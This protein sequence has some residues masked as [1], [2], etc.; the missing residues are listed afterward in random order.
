MKISPLKTVEPP[1]NGGWQ[2]AVLSEPPTSEEDQGAVDRARPAPDDSERQRLFLRRLGEALRAERDE[3]AAANLAL[4]LLGE[5]LGVDRCC[6]AELRAVGDWAT[7]SHQVFRQGLGPLPTLLRPALISAEIRV[8]GDLAEEASLDPD[9]RTALAALGFGAFVVVPLRAGDESP[10]W[11]LVA[12]SAAPRRLSPGDVGLVEEVAERVW[13]AISLRREAAA[14][15]RAEDARRT[16]EEKYR[17][18]FDTIGEGLAIIELIRDATGKVVDVR[19]LEVNEAFEQHTGWRGA[20]GKLRSEIAPIPDEEW[21]A[22]VERLVSAGEP[23]RWEAY[24]RNARRWYRCFLSP[25]GGPG[26]DQIVLV[27]ENITGRKHHERNQALLTGVNDDLARIDDVPATLERLGERI[28][29]HFEV[30]WCAIAS[31]SPSFESSGI[32]HTWNAQDAAEFSGAWRM[33]DLFACEPSAEEEPAVVNDTQNDGRTRAESCAALGIQSCVVVPLVRNGISRFL[34]GIFDRQ[35]RVWRD[36]EVELMRELAQRIWTRLERVQA[37]EALRHSEGQLRT[38]AAE[39][40][41]ADRRKNDFLAMLGHELRNPLAAIRGGI[42]L[43]RSERALPE[44]RA[45]ALPIVAEQVAHMEHLVDDLL[46]LTRI[47]QGRV[48]LRWE[49]VALQD[50]LRQAL[51]MI[52]PQ[53][54]PGGFVIEVNVPETPLE[55]LGDRVRLTQIFMNV[56]GNAVKYSGDSR[57]VEVSAERHGD[58]AVVRVR[59]Y[60]LGIAPEILPRIFEPFVQA[61]PGLTLQAGLGLGLAVVR[62][63]MLLHDGE[64]EALSDGE[65]L[66]SEFVLRLRLAQVEDENVRSAL[67]ANLLDRV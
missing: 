9:E 16:A 10:L 12:A 15:A 55:V 47:V 14:R 49:R 17:T 21:L 29:R 13:A 52:R 59:D 51:E 57:L 48:P 39:L 62:Q 40:Q 44:S 8:V 1:I 2:A 66:G 43:M 65:L 30:P 3:A 50:S 28:A 32:F 25:I 35:V 60:G 23:E 36:D 22:G 33:A 19:Y 54:E 37:E 11:A 56:L 58:T 63:L 31:P 45:A 53:A 7:I 4:Q 27:F 24:S 18:L 34:L 5:E 38:I 41:E 64:V 67:V 46:D 26:S 20:R 61:K 42:K 6:V